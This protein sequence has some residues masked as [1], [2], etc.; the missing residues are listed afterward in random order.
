MRLS[1]IPSRLCRAAVKLL[2]TLVKRFASQLL[3]ID[4][5]ANRW[6]GF[7][8]R[9]FGAPSG[10]KRVIRHGRRGTGV[11]QGKSLN[12]AVR[13]L[14]LVVATY[15][16]A[17]LFVTEAASAQG[18]WPF[19]G[20]GGGGQ[21]EDRPPVPQEPVYRQPPAV[22]RP[23]PAAIFAGPSSTGHSAGL[24]RCACCAAGGRPAAADQLVYKKSDLLSARA[25][26]RAGGPEERPD[27]KRS[28]ACRDRHPR[29]RKGGR[30]N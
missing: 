9:G 12:I 6:L 29:S 8:V 2:N 1:P 23:A 14:L 15:G 7:E 27:A 18:W 11:S 24:A 22:R 25:T 5:L 17:L 26:P 13:R 20:G 30:S 3:R 19:G 21:E 4:R 16:A 10:R 28:A